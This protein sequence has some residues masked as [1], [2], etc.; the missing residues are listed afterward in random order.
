MIA[1]AAAAVIEDARA[2]VSI[3]HALEA[4]GDFAN[5]G[6]PVDFLEGAVG[7][8]PE[9][10]GQPIPAVLVVVNSLR[11]LAGIALRR[12]V[13]AISAHASDMTPVE[14]HLDSAVHAAQDA[15]SF[16]PVVAHGGPP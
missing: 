13:F 11:L 7:P 1:L 4:C 9:R 14:L 8:S 5:R 2:A 6:V 12:D 10:R 16:L 15:N 3:A